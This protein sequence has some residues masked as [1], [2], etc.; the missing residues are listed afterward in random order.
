MKVAVCCIG[1]NENRYAPE[2]VEHYKKLGVDKIFIYD[3]NDTD[4]EHFEDVLNDDIVEIIDYRN[5]KLCQMRSYTECY[6]KHKDEYDWIIFVDFDEFL[7]TRYNN[8]KEFL[9]LPRFKYI[10]VIHI[11]WKCMTDNEQLYYSPKSLFERFTVGK[12]DKHIKSIVRG[13]IN[14]LSFTGNPHC[15][16]FPFLVCTDSLGHPNI[17]NNPFNDRPDD[18]A[19][20]DEACI[21]HFITKSAEEFAYKMMRGYPDQILKKSSM[22]DHIHD[23]FFNVNTYSKEKEDIIMKI[24]KDNNI[25]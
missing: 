22:I 10:D 24:Y 5:Q 14:N 23:Y 12:P 15:P 18:T 13:G 2:F 21:Y 11:N 1:K 16:T 7:C 9:Q 20:F 25:M 17:S 6:N 3:N 4:G 8:I 19:M